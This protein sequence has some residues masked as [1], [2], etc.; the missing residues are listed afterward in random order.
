VCRCVCCED[1]ACADV[2][3]VSSGGFV[4]S[5][6]AVSSGMFMSSDGFVCS[7]GVVYAP[8]TP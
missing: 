6:G 3:G 4:S 7:G 2:W 8:V 1:G 5:G